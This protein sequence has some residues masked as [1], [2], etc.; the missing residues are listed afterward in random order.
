MK[1]VK[2]IKQSAGSAKHREANT[3]IFADG[4]QPLIRGRIWN[5]MKRNCSLFSPQVCFLVSAFYC[6][7]FFSRR[8]MNHQICCE[9]FGCTK[10][11]QQ[12][13]KQKK[14]NGT[15]EE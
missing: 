10:N 2:R 13:T 11:R 8:L 12:A 4:L 1:K 5:W 9:K 6:K 3:D 14:Q 7:K 15:L